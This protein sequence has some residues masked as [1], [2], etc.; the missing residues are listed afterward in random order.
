M[1][2]ITATGEVELG[3]ENVDRK[4]AFPP[5]LSN[6]LALLERDPGMMEQRARNLDSF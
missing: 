1:V 6:L 4:K 2:K 5:S 3:Q